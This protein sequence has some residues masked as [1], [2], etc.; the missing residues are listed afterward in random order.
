MSHSLE[1]SE[2]YSTEVALRG[3]VPLGAQSLH[4]CPGFA[5]LY[6]KR[7][8]LKFKVTITLLRSALSQKSI[9]AVKALPVFSMKQK[10]ESQWE[11]WWIPTGGSRTSLLPH[12]P[13]PRLLV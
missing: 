1:R 5:A 9:A 12:H 7:H 10:P 11:V 6:F 8:S 4:E 3:S 13:E 2:N